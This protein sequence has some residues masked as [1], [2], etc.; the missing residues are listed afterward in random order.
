MH[1]YQQLSVGCFNVYILLLSS[2]LHVS[3]FYQKGAK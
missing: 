3:A 1:I 2:A